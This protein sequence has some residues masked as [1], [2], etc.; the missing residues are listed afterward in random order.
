MGQDQGATS[1]LKETAPR[2]ETKLS[3]HADKLAGHGMKTL[4]MSARLRG[5]VS[6]YSATSKKKE[7]RQYWQYKHSTSGLNKVCMHCYENAE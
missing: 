3:G 7:N 4:E 6:N 2:S 5:K 1:C